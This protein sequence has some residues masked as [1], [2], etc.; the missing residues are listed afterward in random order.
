MGKEIFEQNSN[1]GMKSV[2]KNECPGCKLNPLTNPMVK[3]RQECFKIDLRTKL[4]MH[5]TEWCRL[6][7]SHTFCFHCRLLFLVRVKSNDVHGCLSQGCGNVFKKDLSLG[8]AVGL[9]AGVVREYLSNIH[10]P[11]TTPSDN[12]LVTDLI[13]SQKNEEN[14]SRKKKEQLWEQ[15]SQND[16]KL[17]NFEK[18]IQNAEIKLKEGKQ[19]LEDEFESLKSQIEGKIRQGMKER[20][21]IDAKIIECDTEVRKRKLIQEHFQKG[22]DLL[23]GAIDVNDNAVLEELRT[24]RE[25]APKRIK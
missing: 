2:L 17:K 10:L 7:C 15:R 5:F 16:K 13:K 24:N 19:K 6:E 14:Q 1:I 11:T 21:E 8:N 18:E 22:K 9:Y 4:P 3:K 12:E 25:S 23:A 20:D